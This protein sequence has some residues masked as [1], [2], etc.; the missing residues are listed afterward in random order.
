MIPK[1]DRGLNHTGR[2][3]ARDDLGNE[4]T[5]NE[6]SATDDELLDEDDLIAAFTQSSGKTYTFNGSI[7]LAGANGAFATSASAPFI[8]LARVSGADKIRFV[9]ATG[10]PAVLE[11]GTDGIRW[12]G[13]SSTILSRLRQDSSLQLGKMAAGTVPNTAVQ[14]FLRDNGT[15]D[16]LVAKFGRSG[17]VRVLATS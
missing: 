14:V 4:S 12:G 3:F 6:A 16:Q 10:S 9:P 2:V 11:V 8:E 5:S 13:S 17:L 15:T 1:A 7:V